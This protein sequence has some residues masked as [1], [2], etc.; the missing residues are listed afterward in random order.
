MDIRNIVICGVGGQGV[1]LA[2]R[3]LA[4][5]FLEAGMDVKQSEVHGMAQRGGSVQSHVR[6]GK[7]VH[8]PVVPMGK[9]DAVIGFEMLEALRG[10]TYLR[11]GGLLISSTERIVP[12]VPVP[13]V[14]G[15]PERIED[16]VLTAAER[17]VLLDAVG[18]ALETGER[19]AANMVLVGAL[20]GFMDFEKTT[21][22][23]ALRSSI[24]EKDLEVNLHAFRQGKSAASQTPPSGAWHEREKEKD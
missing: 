2:A 24:R 9:A 14:P 7:Q 10:S 4:S 11:P 20:S 12:A 15:Y 13:G 17:V 5:A 8:S 21:W 6:G 19:R 16:E 18:V 23:R 22:E 1:I 3:V